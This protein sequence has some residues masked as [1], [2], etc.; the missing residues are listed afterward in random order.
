M[1]IFYNIPTVYFI[2]FFKFYCHLNGQVDIYFIVNEW[3]TTC[4]WYAF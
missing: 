4:S 1:G 3:V 2:L